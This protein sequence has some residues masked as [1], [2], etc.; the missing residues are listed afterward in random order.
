MDVNCECCHGVLDLLSSSGVSIFQHPRV[1]V[2]WLQDSGIHKILCKK[3]LAY[4]HNS[5]CKQSGCKPM[6]SFL[7]VSHLVSGGHI[8]A[9]LYLTLNHIGARLYLALPA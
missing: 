2:G 3:M 1:D 6:S 9:R 8:G 4:Y 5:S 7:L